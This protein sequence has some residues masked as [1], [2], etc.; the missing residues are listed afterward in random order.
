MSPIPHDWPHLDAILPA[1]DRWARVTA[2]SVAAAHA[3]LGFAERLDSRQ[4]TQWLA[5]WVALYV[6][7]HQG[8]QQFWGY[9]SNGDRAA[10]LLKPLE[11]A[12]A[13]TRREIRRLLGVI[14]DAGSLVAR[15]VL[16]LFVSGRI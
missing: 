9:G 7:E 5:N 6:D 11:H 8:D 15:D 14:A 10:A 3:L 1:I 12:D 16:S 13:T 2:Y 4:R